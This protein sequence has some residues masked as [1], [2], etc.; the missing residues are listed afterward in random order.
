[1]A[2]ERG[3]PVVRPPES[4][5]GREGGCT[6]PSVLTA[7]PALPAAHM[8]TQAPLSPAGPGAGC[9]EVSGSRLLA[10]NRVGVFC[11]KLLLGPQQRSSVSVLALSRGQDAVSLFLALRTL[12]C[13]EPRSATGCELGGWPRRRPAGK[14]LWSRRCFPAHSPGQA[15]FSQE[16]TPE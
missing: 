4:G 10:C 14:L 12:K 8:G 11:R 6:E 1:M 5:A 16:T 13:Q 3:A 9:R 2:P 15:V 7:S